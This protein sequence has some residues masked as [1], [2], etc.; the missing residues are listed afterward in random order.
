MFLPWAVARLNSLV[1]YEHRDRHTLSKNVFVWCVWYEAETLK[2]LFLIFYLS[3]YLSI[4]LFHV[5]FSRFRPK[6]SLTISVVLLFFDCSLAVSL[7]KRTTLFSP[8]NSFRFSS[9]L[10]LHWSIYKRK[11]VKSNFSINVEH[12]AIYNQFVRL[13]PS[14]ARP[15]LLP[16][17]ACI[18][19][20]VTWQ[21]H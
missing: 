5:V 15:H 21:V 12:E 1:C 6:V 11:H 2:F 13:M 8:H 14:T 7:T 3:V 9:L 20:V 18:S 16:E 4:F 17:P 10:Q 19:L